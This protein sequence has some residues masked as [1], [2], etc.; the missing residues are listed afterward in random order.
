MELIFVWLPLVAAGAVVLT[1]ALALMLRPRPRRDD[2]QVLAA[3]HVGRL[4][5]LPAYRWAFRR[6][7]AGLVL[8]TLSALAALGFSTIVA[9]RPISAEVLDSDLDNRDIVLCLD[10]SGSMT[11][12]DAKVLDYF[13]DLVEHFRGER[14]SLVLWSAN[15]VTVF[16]LTDDYPYLVRTLQEVRDQTAFTSDIPIYA[17]TE[18]VDDASLVGD[19]LVSCVQEFDHSDLARSRTIV[20]A[21]D[22]LVGY[23]P[24]F[25]LEEATDFA[26]DAEVRVYG[27]APLPG[28]A[29]DEMTSELQRTGGDVVL[30]T[31]L[32]GS[33]RIIDAVLSDQAATLDGVPQ[34]AITDSPGRWLVYAMLALWGVI[35]AAWVVRS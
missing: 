15:P 14:V 34:L 2:A 23:E 26:I 35:G 21:T 9:A 3:A 19:G 12:A 6:A 33:Q 22:N 11:S 17:G 24:L 28:Y 20:L 1:V 16:P 4:L 25:S 18:I 8:L 29:T 7:L 31:D 30:L 27:L 13:A 10:V 32:G 5:D